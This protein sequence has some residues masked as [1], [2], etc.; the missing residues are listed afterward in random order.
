MPAAIEPCT[1]E[2]NLRFGAGVALCDE[3]AREYM[4]LVI[5]PPLRD[6]DVAFGHH[7]LE[8]TAVA[9]ICV[10][11]RLVPVSRVVNM[12]F[13]PAAPRPWS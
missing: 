12:P 3:R 7:D 11:R 9:N 6:R 4:S 2:E 1:V 10:A 13:V 5:Q 8:E